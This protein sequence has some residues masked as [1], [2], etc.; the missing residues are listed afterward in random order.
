MGVELTL[1]DSNPWLEDVFS[2]PVD[3]AGICFFSHLGYCEKDMPVMLH[4][5]PSKTFVYSLLSKDRILNDLD[6]VHIASIRTGSYLFSLDAADYPHGSDSVAFYAISME[7]VGYARSDEAYAIHRIVSKFDSRWSVV[8][9]RHLDSLM[10][11]FL[12]PNQDAGYA[13][14]LSDWLSL[15]DGDHGQLA[16]IHVVNTSLE[17][18]VDCFDGFM[19]ESI[20]P[21]YKYPITRASAVYSILDTLDVSMTIDLPL[22]PREELDSA[23]DKVMSSYVDMYGDDYIEDK[24]LDYDD[25]DDFDLDDI[26]W[27]LEN[28]DLDKSED[29]GERQLKPPLSFDTPLDS[30][31]VIR[32]IPD[33][34]MASPVALLKW[35]ESHP[36]SESQT[37]DSSSSQKRLRIVPIESKPPKTGSYVRHISMG[38]GIVTWTDASHIKVDFG[39]TQRVFP[40]PGAFDSGSLVLLG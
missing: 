23:A 20:R 6:V 27:E 25:D 5:C 8:L 32:D 35:M 17:S 11:S 36:D 26:E 22:I 24:T 18:P 14:Y 15:S 2:L 40:F 10:L 31:T 38:K 34:V 13:I 16:R 33:E 3:K 37:T 4:A 30:R 21:Y 39:S 28:S 1:Y 7:D 29:P 19:F 9:F 12:K